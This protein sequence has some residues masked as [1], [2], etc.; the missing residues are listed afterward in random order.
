MPACPKVTVAIRLAMVSQLHVCTLLFLAQRTDAKDKAIPT[1]TPECHFGAQICR[2]CRAVEPT[3]RSLHAKR[4]F[5]GP[6]SGITQA[7]TK[8]QNGRQSQPREGAKPQPQHE[9][10]CSE[11]VDHTSLVLHCFNFLFPEQQGRK[12][13]QSRPMEGPRMPP[14]PADFCREDIGREGTWRKTLGQRCVSFFQ[15]QR[16]ILDP[17]ERKSRAKEAVKAVQ[18]KVR[19]CRRA[20]HISCRFRWGWR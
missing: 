15:R 12:D 10:Y 3:Y 6:E 13:S 7:R 8:F 1:R 16:R 2:L 20:R 14:R 17:P 5:A 18:Q 19:K 9:D 11:H 4:R